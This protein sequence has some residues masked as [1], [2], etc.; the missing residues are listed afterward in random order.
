MTSE[1]TSVSL[2][3]SQQGPNP[4]HVTITLLG[5]FWRGNPAF[6]PSGA[7]VRLLGELAISESS[8]RS[9]LSRLTGRAVLTAA[10]HG[11]HTSYR[12]SERV[13]AVGAETVRHIFEAALEPPPQWDGEWTIVAFSLPSDRE[14]Q[15]SSLRT[16]L[17]WFGFAPLQDGVWVS[18]APFS[19]ALAAVLDEVPAEYVTAFRASVASSETLASRRVG[20]QSGLDELAER[21]RSVAAECARVRAAWDAGDLSPAS[22]FRERIL[23]MDAWRD[24]YRADPHLPADLL[25]PEWPRAAAGQAFV[26]VYDV[27]GPAAEEH[28]RALVEPFA[29]DPGDL[30]RHFTSSS[31]TAG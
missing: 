2:P 7:I 31:A 19:A 20:A 1:M 24:L 25:P 22:A 16:K 26:G 23:L 14:S 27:L 28:A 29:L 13:E 9:A 15:R 18:A 10:K 8:A 30:P 17:R 4:Q 11:R 5:D 3:R 12:L 21:Y 6:V